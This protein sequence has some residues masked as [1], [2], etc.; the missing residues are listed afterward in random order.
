[1]YK[2]IITIY[3]IINIYIY[4]Y[5]HGLYNI[6]MIFLVKVTRISCDYN[7]IKVTVV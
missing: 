7:K 2:K 4:I 3:I 1:M 5:I 6:D